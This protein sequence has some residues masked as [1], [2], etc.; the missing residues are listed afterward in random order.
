MSLFSCSILMLFYFILFLFMTNLS[1]SKEFDLVNNRSY[2][3][4]S[5]N[6]FCSGI[7]VAI[8]SFHVS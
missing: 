6:L 1:N 3:F 8:D 5:D 4:S 7:L 2:D